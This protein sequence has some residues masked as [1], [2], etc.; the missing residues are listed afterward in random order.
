VTSKNLIATE[1]SEVDLENMPLGGSGTAI[2]GILPQR[3]VDPELRPYVG[4]PS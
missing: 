2:D 1:G 3:D 4:E